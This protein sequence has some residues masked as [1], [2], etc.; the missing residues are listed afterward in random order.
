M[1]NPATNTTTPSNPPYKLMGEPNQR[2]TFGIT[3]FCLSTLI[4]C[5]WSTLHFNIPTRRYTD[6][7]RFFL[8][9]SWMIV[10]LLAPE[11]LLYLA[12]NERITAGI[13]LKKVLK[14]HPHLA[15]PRVLARMYNWIRGRAESKAMSPQYQAYVIL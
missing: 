14:L 13:L 10:A 1:E 4:I 9:V 5:I 7:R 6:I 2:G 3:S 8:Q 15:K 11:V 12:I